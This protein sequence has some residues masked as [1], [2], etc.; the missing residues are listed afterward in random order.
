MPDLPVELRP[1]RIP[2]PGRGGSVSAYELGPADRPVDVVFSHANGFNALTYRTILAPLADARRVLAYDF[3]GH[4]GSDLPAVTAG[5]DDWC[6]LGEDLVALL[7]GLDLTDVVLAGHSMGATSSILAAA[8]APRRVRALALFDPVVMPP[9]KAGR[10]AAGAP[11]DSPMVQGALRRRTRFPSIE[12]AIDAFV[13]RGVLAPWP[14]AIVEDYVRGGLRPTAEGDFVLA[15]APEWEASGYTAQGHDVWGALAR[16]TAPMRLLRAEKASTAWVDS[17]AGD[18]RL[19]IETIPGTT[20]FL[21]M[22]RP[23]L[24]VATLAELTA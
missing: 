15:C 19:R 5:R 8:G 18:P 9:E 16:V 12:T 23:D 20:H 14:R 2:L 24:V 4:G 10:P 3:R 13:G 7:D 21:P 1:R 11:L 22:E 6:D 17:L